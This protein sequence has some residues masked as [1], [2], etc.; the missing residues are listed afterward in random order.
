MK[1]YDI[2][3]SGGGIIGLAIA[4]GLQNI[5][6]HILIVERKQLK[7][8][9]KNKMPLPDPERFSALNIASKYFFQNLG[10]WQ[11]ILDLCAN[12]FNGVEVWDID[13]FGKIHFN[14]KQQ[15]IQEPLGYIVSN[16]K[17]HDILLQHTQVFGD[18]TIC[19]SATL[20][21]ISFK[22]NNAIIILDN[23]NT[24]TTRLIIAA[25]GTHSWL[26]Q[27]FKIP[28]SFWKY[29]HHA[30]VATIRTEKPHQEIAYQVFHSNS[31]LAVLPLSNPYLSSIVWSLPP[32]QACFFQQA[33]EIL[34]NQHLSIHFDLCLGVC[35]LVSKR[36]T[37]PLTG[38]YAHHL[39][40]HRLTLV[41]DAAHTIHPL[42]GQGLNIG[43]MDAA[44]LVGTI[45]RIQNQGGD[46]GQYDNLRSYER[47]RKYSSFLA[48]TGAQGFY[49]IFNGNNI[50]KKLLRN[51]LLKLTNHIPAV[52]SCLLQHAQ[53]IINIPPWLSR[54]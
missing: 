14:P 10:I 50:G 29:R 35:Q 49:I 20:Q 41:G 7:L 33:S 21:N 4:C 44:E 8:P 28:S 46:I 32:E 37:L 47:S 3:I 52:K 25:D 16:Q 39:V 13:S 43:L 34:F 30:L 48:L 2:V 23:G 26:R 38:C 45:R 53:G 17:C 40:A 31:I 18:V 9:L 11:Q 6:L 36:Q 19:T 12:E 5:G 24:L 1:H 42:I 27:Y 54:L 15:S 51:S 22:K